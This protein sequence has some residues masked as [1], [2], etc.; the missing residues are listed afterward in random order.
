MFNLLPEKEKR[1]IKKQYRMRRCVVFLILFSFIFLASLIFIVPSYILTV[2]KVQEIEQEI[3]SVQ[4]QLDRKNKAQ[5]S[6]QL[7]EL[8]VKIETI[9]SDSSGLLFYDLIKKVLAKKPADVLVKGVLINSSI[10]DDERVY[11]IQLTGEAR[12]RSA[13]VQYKNVLERG[14]DY[15]TVELPIESLASQFDTPFDL[16]LTLSI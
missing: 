16:N 3:Q 10:V 7:E 9:S 8:R 1:E 2:Y 5:L 15:D 4:N 14:G 6:M 11:K 13:I 12:T